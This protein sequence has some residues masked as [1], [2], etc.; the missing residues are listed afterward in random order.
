MIFVI[1][2]LLKDARER[3]LAKTFAKSKSELSRLRFVL[4]PS[5]VLSPLGS[6]LCALCVRNRSELIRRVLSVSPCGIRNLRVLP[7]GPP[8]HAAKVLV[9]P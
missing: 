6:E 8:P 2:V 9:V 5:F 3:S 4:I 1:T 7:V